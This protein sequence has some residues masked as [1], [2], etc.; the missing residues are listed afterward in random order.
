[1]FHVLRGLL[2]LVGP[3]IGYSVGKTADAALVGLGV[4]AFVVAIELVIERIPLDVLI[5]G[6]IGAFGGVIIAK[7][8]DWLVFRLD[9][10][11]IYQF[12]SNKSL[13]VNLVF[14]YLGCMIAVRKKGELDLLDKNLVVKST[15]SKEVKI[16]DT[17]VLIDGRLADVVET[18]FLSGNLI[19]PRFV[20]HELQVVADS[21]DGTKRQRGRRG[22]DIL[23]RL[24]DSQEV[25]V[26]IYDK[27]Y[28]NIK[29]VDSKLVELAKEMDGKVA[30]TDFNL[31]KVAALQGVPVLNVNDLAGALKS[32]VLP[33]DTLILYLAKEGKEKQQAVG[34]LDDGTMVVVDDGRRYLG[35][36][37]S[38]YVNSILQ[39]PAGRMIFARAQEVKEMPHVEEKHP[40]PGS[41]SAS[42]ESHPPHS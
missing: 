7:G 42:N 29:E 28:P 14:A 19:V 13:L 30:T 27:D 16:I 31:S 37:V 34:Y 10:P 38:A 4:S 11:A 39:T 26:K 33:G 23:K 21:S 41:P 5:F 17:S 18:G 36:R 40:L 20:L 1:M 8:I 25:T 3:I 35:K 32:V 6:A 15:K 22:L 12:I 2:L 9:N 24:Q